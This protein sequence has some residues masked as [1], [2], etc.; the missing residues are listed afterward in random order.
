MQLNVL[1]HREVGDAARIAPSDAGDGSQLVGL[2]QA[3]GNSN[4]HHEE[5]QGPS[6]AVLA[7]HH[8]RAIALRVDSPPAEVRADP[9]G[10]NRVEAFARKPA[11]LGQTVPRI[12][13]ALQSFDFLRFGFFDRICH[14]L[15]CPT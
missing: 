11:N 8:S 15:I 5:R 14:K 9:L 7:A 1:P 13:R 2:Q 6:L 10:W 12:H 4:P 3:V